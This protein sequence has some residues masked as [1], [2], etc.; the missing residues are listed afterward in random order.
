[1]SVREGG[2]DGGWEREME[3]DRE[4]CQLTFS[5]GEN[6]QA[7]VFDG[8]DQESSRGFDRISGLIFLQ[9]LTNKLSILSFLPD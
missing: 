3:G 8:A 2:G 4:F 1:M 6:W 7:G 9:L 5:H